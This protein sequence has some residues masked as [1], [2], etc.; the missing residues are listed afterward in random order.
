MR[1]YNMIA[2]KIPETALISR[3]A[4]INKRMDNLFRDSNNV[5]KDGNYKC[6]MSYQFII[7]S[8]ILYIYIYL[9]YLYESQGNA[10]R[11]LHFSEYHSRK[12]AQKQNDNIKPVDKHT[13]SGGIF[14]RVKVRDDDEKYMIINGMYSG[15]KSELMNSP[16]LSFFSPEFR[17]LLWEKWTEY[18]NIRVFSLEKREHTDFDR[19]E[20]TPN[21][22]MCVL[23]LSSSFLKE[24]LNLRGELSKNFGFFL[25]YAYILLKYIFDYEGKNNNTLDFNDVLFDGVLGIPSAEFIN[26]DKSIIIYL[27]KISKLPKNKKDRLRNPK[28]L[29]VLNDLI[30]SIDISK[31]S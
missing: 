25:R 1:S 27:K 11:E 9:Q 4:I 6:H 16:S 13:L 14:E 31:V 15:M 21:L 20:K 10:T 8:I 28:V 12:L 19:L 26:D 5:S 29:E 2:C 3:N 30:R 24:Y 18:S 23:T 7:V 17:T 22:H